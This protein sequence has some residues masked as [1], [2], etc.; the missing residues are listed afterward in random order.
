MS[1]DRNVLFPLKK[2]FCC[3]RE[4][5]LMLKNELNALKIAI[6]DCISKK[7]QLSVLIVSLSYLFYEEVLQGAVNYYLAFNFFTFCFILFRY[8]IIDKYKMVKYFTKL[9]RV[10]EES[11]I[12]QSGQDD[13][14]QQGPPSTSS[15]FKKKIIA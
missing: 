2:H 9:K 13:N 8:N 3:Q 4:N 6:S 1:H 5:S 11:K 12:I 14:P 10:A 7:T 15:L